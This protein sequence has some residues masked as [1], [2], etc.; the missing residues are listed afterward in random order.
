MAKGDCIYIDAIYVT[1]DIPPMSFENRKG[2]ECCYDLPVLWYTN[3][4]D[5]DY[6]YKHDLTS[7]V[8]FMDKL[9]TSYTITLQKNRCGWEDLQELE[10]N[11]LG[12]YFLAP[13]TNRL[14][15]L[16]TSDAADE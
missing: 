16:Y 10:D 6:F 15:L 2:A 11:S 4:S 13:D 1:P 7:W 14:C 9:A 5:P 3:A 8:V 12:T